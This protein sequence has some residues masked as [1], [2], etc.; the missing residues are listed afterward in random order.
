VVAGL[1]C[2]NGLKP[3]FRQEKRFGM[4]G[5]PSNNLALNTKSLAGFLIRELAGKEQKTVVKG[6]IIVCAQNFRSINHHKLF[7]LRGAATV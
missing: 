5:I 7:C 4:A 6:F 3:R 2:L 1:H